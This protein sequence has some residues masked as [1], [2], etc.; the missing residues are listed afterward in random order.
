MP[1]ADAYLNKGRQL[2][3]N[4]GRKTTERKTKVTAMAAR[5]APIASQ[6]MTHSSGSQLRRCF[7]AKQTTTSN[8]RM[9]MT[10]L[11]EACMTEIA[12]LTAWTA[13]GLTRRMIL[14]SL[15]LPMARAAALLRRSRSSHLAINA[16]QATLEI[17]DHTA[18]SACTRGRPTRR[19]LK[20]V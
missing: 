7:G 17:A 11:A 8:T 19:L 1:A 16:R 15:A 2:G 9:A 18:E 10:S 5:T 20:L 3:T 13:S 4:S 12:A 6:M 14:T